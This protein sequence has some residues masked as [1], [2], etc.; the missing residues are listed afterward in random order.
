MDAQK[1]RDEFNARQRKVTK[2]WQTFANGTG[3][4]A[5][6]DLMAFIDDTREMYRKY[7]EERAMPHPD[8][9]KAMAGAV[10]AIDNDTV[11]ALLQNS[12]GLSIVQTYIRNRI[13]TDVA[14]P[15]KLSK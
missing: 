4:I 14:Q 9:Q 12:R 13:D 7:A 15:K 1:Q 3:K 2:Q 8:P 5:Y 11:A 6:Q 10:V